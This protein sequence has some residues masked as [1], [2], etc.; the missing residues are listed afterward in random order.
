MYIILR[1]SQTPYRPG[2]SSNRGRSIQT[3]SP[4]APA[5]AEC[6]LSMTLDSIAA[7]LPLLEKLVQDVHVALWTTQIYSFCN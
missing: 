4:R 2:E 5:G 3:Q 7:L 1:G 6:P